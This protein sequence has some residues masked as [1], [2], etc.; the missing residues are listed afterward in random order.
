MRTVDEQLDLPVR[1]AVVIQ[2]RR[3]DTLLRRRILTGNIF[4][5]R[6]FSTMWSSIF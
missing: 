4:C 6:A 2:K 1:E 5:R 3:E